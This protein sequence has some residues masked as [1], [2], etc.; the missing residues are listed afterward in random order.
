MLVVA[1]TLGLA[2]PFL[3]SS[4]RT[5]VG[6]FNYDGMERAGEVGGERVFVSREGE[7]ATASVAS[8]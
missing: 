3:I 2:T 1:V 8:S 6:H 7:A 5:E 4:S